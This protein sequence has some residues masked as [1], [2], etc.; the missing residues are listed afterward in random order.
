MIKNIIILTIALLGLSA[1]IFGDSFDKI[2]KHLSQEGCHSFSFI[3]IITSDIF[4]QTDTTHGTAYLASDGRYN[5]IIGDEQFLYDLEYVYSYS[6]SNNQ[7]IIENADVAVVDEISFLTKLD[8][9]YETYILNPNKKYQLVKRKNITGD[10]KDTLTVM[11]DRKKL[12]LKQIEYY[13]VNNE[14]NMI[15]ILKQN[16]MTDCDENKFEPTFPDSVE[17]VKLLK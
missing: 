17:R 14:L 6:I 9:I 10:Y 7:I 11:I 15:V 4:E 13:D 2:K 8:E 3:S 5:L 1:N 12:L 16:Y